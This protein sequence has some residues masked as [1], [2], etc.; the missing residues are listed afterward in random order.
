MDSPGIA[1][2][3]AAPFSADRHHRMVRCEPPRA[4]RRKLAHRL[5]LR[6]TR[7]LSNGRAFTQ[8][9]RGIGAIVSAVSN[10][11]AERTLGAVPW[12]LYCDYAW[13]LSILALAVDNAS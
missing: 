6:I 11:H 5:V 12:H 2:R 3:F 9:S 10:A 13:N 4:G 8:L 7:G 1:R